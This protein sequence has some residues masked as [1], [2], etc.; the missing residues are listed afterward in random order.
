MRF[1]KF[2]QTQSHRWHKYCNT[3][4][5]TETLRFQEPLGFSTLCEILPY[6]ANFL[7]AMTWMITDR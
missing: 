2:E 5:I 1:P 4:S 3:Y 7:S 6:D